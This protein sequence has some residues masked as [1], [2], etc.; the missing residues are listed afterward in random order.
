MYIMRKIVNDL[1]LKYREIIS[2]GFWGV[3]TT[4]LN[5]VVYFSC[6]KGFNINYL[7]SNIVAWIIAV[8]FA[9]VTNKVFVFQSNEWKGSIVFGEFCK[10]ISARLL[11]G[12]I[13]IFILYIFVDY[14]SFRDDIVKIFTNILIVVINYVFSKSIIFKDKKQK[15]GLYT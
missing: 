11:S 14:L 7:V 8:V 9:F 1:Y 13:E 15:N 6:T 4:I 2:Y 3:M 10:F 5:Y 12:V